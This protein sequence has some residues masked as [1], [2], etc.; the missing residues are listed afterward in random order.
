MKVTNE[1]D[2][3]EAQAKQREAS[4]RATFSK[5]KKKKRNE[6]EV[7][8]HVDGEELTMLLR[9]VSSEEYDALLAKFPPTPEQKR[10][11]A[12]WNVDTFPPALFAS[13]CVEPDLTIEEANELWA[14]DAYSR[15]DLQTLWE[16]A[17]AVVMVGF[18][19]PFNKSA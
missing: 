6:R 13:V 8:I 2:V 9:A 1:A 12:A 19:V 11:G 16:A 10:E 7:S 17:I 18:D 3:V 4:K 5:L 15:G 14:S